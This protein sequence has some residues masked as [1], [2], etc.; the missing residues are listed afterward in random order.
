[1]FSVT[2]WNMNVLCCCKRERKKLKIKDEGMNA[3]YHH[4]LFTEKLGVDVL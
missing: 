2:L 4:V 1:M 3:P